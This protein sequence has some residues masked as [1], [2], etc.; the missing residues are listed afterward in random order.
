MSHT[1]PSLIPDVQSHPD[2]R[3]LAIDRVGIRDLRYPLS[4]VDGEGPVQ[5]IVARCSVFVALAAERKGTHMSRLVAAIDE[6]SDPLSLVKLPALV[7]LVSAKV[8]LA[9]RM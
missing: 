2:A 5:R 4:F 1:E 8:P 6:F 9:T 7:D 3:Q